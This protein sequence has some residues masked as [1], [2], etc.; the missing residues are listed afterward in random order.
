[1]TRVHDM[2]GR[3]G[4]GPVR[5]EPPTVNI[6]AAWEARALALVLAA[7][8]AR[9]WNIDENRHARES[10]APADYARFGYYEKWLAGM[11]DLLAAKGIVGADELARGHAAT[12]AERP[13][14][15]ALPRAGVAKVLASGG[16][17]LRDGG[18]APDFAPGDRVVTRRLAANTAVA[19]G[20]TRLPSYAAGASGTVLRRHGN[21]V[22][23][24]SSAH[25]LGDC[26]EPLY[27]VAFD[28][29]ALWGASE[30]AG[31][32]VILDLWQSYLA[33]A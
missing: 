11:A 20:H 33:P 3:F 21:H 9:L 32:E 31:D 12:V 2:G 4:D 26:P 13:L 6:G 24:D 25:G 5:P 1:M 28:A 29:G 7:G 19:G 10:L 27:A 30:R 15:R 17:S 8:A 22:F 18:P 14:P 23:P 16:P